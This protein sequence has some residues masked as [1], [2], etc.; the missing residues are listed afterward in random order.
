MKAKKKVAIVGIVGLPANYGGFET[1]V[2]YF[3]LQKN[4][5]FDFT[6]FCQKTLKK[7]Q[8]SVFN[9]SRL[10]Y[11][12]FNANG[13]QSVIYDIYSLIL[14]WFKYDVIL[15]LGTPGCVILP[16]LRIFKK[17]RSLLKNKV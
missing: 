6:V 7:K 3:T 10:K 9:G 5:E 8:L 11:L 14:S 4:Q 17:S 15:I 1:M 2:N 13:L 16:V 12:P